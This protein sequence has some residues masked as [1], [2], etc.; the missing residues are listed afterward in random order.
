MRIGIV[1]PRLLAAEAIRRVIARSGKHDVAWIAQD[2][3]EAVARCRRDRPDLVLMDLFMPRLDGVEATRQIM[4]HSPCAIIVATAKVE[5][6][7]GKVFEVMGAGAIDAVSLP[8][9]ADAASLESARPLLAKLETIRRL[10][11]SDRKPVSPPAPTRAKPCGLVAI[12]ASAGGPTA[13]AT[14]LAA[15]PA[16]FPAAVVIVQHMDKQFAPGLTAWFSTHTKLAVRVA[17]EGDRVAPGT[18]YLAGRDQ[19]LILS[20]P[21]QLGYSSQPGNTPYCPSVDVFFQSVV[22]QW[23][24]EVVGVLLTGMGRDGAEGLKTLRRAG[25]HT[26]A[27][28]KSTSAVYG[29][30]KA[31]AALEAANEILALDKIGL[32]LTNMFRLK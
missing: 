8:D 2:G 10:L 28:D 17:Q 32:C 24:G 3:V 23:P 16:R 15:L 29:M 25:H 19:H 9:F 12:G 26:I 1:N 6:H 27:Q 7:M 4:A 22:R 11:G 31:A 20:N 18:A 13:L 5:D 30:P 14:I 21:T